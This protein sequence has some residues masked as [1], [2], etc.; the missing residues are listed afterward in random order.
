MDFVIPY[1][2]D[3]HCCCYQTH[4]V[5]SVFDDGINYYVAEQNNI[6]DAYLVVCR[7]VSF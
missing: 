1:K 5:I 6:A 3:K 2:I 7:R 4:M